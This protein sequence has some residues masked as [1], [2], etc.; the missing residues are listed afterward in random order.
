MNDNLGFLPIQVE[1]LRDDGYVAPTGPS[2]AVVLSQEKGPSAWVSLG[3]VLELGI[4]LHCRH[5]V[6]TVQFCIA[7][8]AESRCPK[9]SRM[10]CSFSQGETLSSASLR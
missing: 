7:A 10:T 5:Y 9:H 4:T 6:S 1:S 3:K 2:E 8:S